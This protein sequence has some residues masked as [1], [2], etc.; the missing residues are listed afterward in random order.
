[1]SK[2]VIA[3]L[4]GLAGLVLLG[5]AS[6]APP[7]P[8]ARYAEA[9]AALD[10]KCDEFCGYGINGSLEER[11]ALDALWDATQDWTVAYLSDRRKI[12]LRKINT[13]LV[14]RHAHERTN[15][16]PDAIFA[17]QPGLYGVLS[18]WEWTGNVFLVEKHEGRF[19]VAWDI[20]KADA[21]AF[22]VLKA[23]HTDRARNDCEKDGNASRDVC[24]PI[25]G[26]EIK[27]LPRDGDGRVRFALLATYGQLAET[28]V[29]GQLSIWTWDGTAPRIQWA[30]RYTYNFEDAS[31]RQHGELLKIRATGW[32]RMFFAC[33]TCIGRQMNWTIRI[34]PH[35][36]DDLG[37][38]PV[39]AELDALDE[40]FYRVWKHLPADDL[41]TSKVQETAAKIITEREAEEASW[42]K[43][44]SG[45]KD[46][47]YLGMLAG[48]PKTTSE[49]GG[50]S[51]CFI[52]DDS[53]PLRTRFENR[54]GALFATE[55]T[56]FPQSDSCP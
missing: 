22:P 19:R 12:D 6:A 14:N 8:E 1:M 37:M 54:A 40:I 52:T 27:L 11:R 41:A 2:A 10:A 24:G 21:G 7:T 23:W 5:Q 32:W 29:A 35:R 46:Y 38:T 28:T 43:D 15:I 17:L 42:P 45:N 50:H 39:V 51:I 48:L 34:G 44:G 18:S 36:I 33:G 47:L 4:G 56:R 16:A 9:L 26:N 3:A 55:M 20:R 31:W 13:D 53:G 49:R 25:I 30:K